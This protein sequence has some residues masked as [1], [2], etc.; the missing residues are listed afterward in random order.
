MEALRVLPGVGPKSA[1]R[2]AL[3]LIERQRSGAL[4]LAHA[5]TTAMDQVKTCTQCRFYTDQTLCALCTDERRDASLLCVVESPLDV[6]ALE[7]SHGYQGRYFVLHGRLSPLDGLGPDEIGLPH[8]LAH[9]QAH[10]QIRELIIATN[11]TLEGDATAHYLME[12]C[13]GLPLTVSRLAQGVP[14][15]GELDALTGRTLHQA[16][17]GRRPMT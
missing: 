5:L 8:L 14:M 3:H 16:L 6:L 13:R 7:H 9:L 11:P 1:Q 2:M 15:G 17:M 4:R 10:P 12:A